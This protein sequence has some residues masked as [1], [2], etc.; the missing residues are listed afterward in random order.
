MI[1]NHQKLDYREKS[2]IEKVTIKAPFH[3]SVIFPDEACFI[4]FEKGETTI[5]SPFDQMP[6]KS[7][8]SVLLKCG[9]YFADFLKYAKNDEY[10]VIV[11]HLPKSVLQ[12]IYQYEIPEFSEIKQKSTHIQKIHS[13]ELIKE[14]IKSLKFYFDNPQLVSEQLLSLKIKELVLFLLQTNNAD[15]IQSLFQQ[16]FTPYLVDIK[17][18]V[19]NHL[20]SNISF[21]DLAGL[22]NMSLSTFKRQFQ[23]TFNVTPGSYFKRKRLEKARELLQ[24]SKLSVSEIAYETCFSDVGHFSRSFKSEYNCTPT[25]YR[26]MNN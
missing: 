11:F 6:V 1:I 23:K 19:Q 22:C 9:T 15:S 18:V 12:E 21:E 7:N 13:Q 2:L 16:L 3:F 24:I 8:E 17:E 14:F 10:Q 20:F 26:Q 5:K 4:F 25:E